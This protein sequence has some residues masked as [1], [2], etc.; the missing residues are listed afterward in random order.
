[1]TPSDLHVG[2]NDA[3]V[4]VC[5]MSRQSRDSLSFHR[6]KEL[7]LRLRDRR[8]RSAIRDRPWG[9]RDAPFVACTLKTFTL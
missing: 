7:R 5:G 2:V 4:E 1:M 6:S 8:G 3:A 9:L